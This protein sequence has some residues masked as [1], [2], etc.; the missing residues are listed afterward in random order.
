MTVTYETAK[1]L[2]HVK[3]PGYNTV[4]IISTALYVTERTFAV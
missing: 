4:L 3:G 1:N 2:R